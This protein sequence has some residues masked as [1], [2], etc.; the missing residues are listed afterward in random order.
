MYTDGTSNDQRHFWLGDK[1][2]VYVGQNVYLETDIYLEAKSTAT[3]ASS[4]LM[5]IITQKK[6]SGAENNPFGWT[7]DGTG[8]GHLIHVDSDGKLYSKGLLGGTI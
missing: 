2:K 7:S 3:F 6:G 1:D 4:S 5:A 8:Y